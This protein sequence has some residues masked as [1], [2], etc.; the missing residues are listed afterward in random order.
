MAEAQLAAGF[1]EVEEVL[2]DLLCDIPLARQYFDTMRAQV[3]QAGVLAPRHAATAAAA[4]P[5][6]ATQQ[7]PPTATQ[8]PPLLRAASAASSIG[9]Y[10][11]AVRMAMPFTALMRWP[12]RFDCVASVVP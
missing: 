6:L 9:D 1:G 8:P 12:A 7:Q 11:T 5:D 2:E 4:Q 3:E 10:G